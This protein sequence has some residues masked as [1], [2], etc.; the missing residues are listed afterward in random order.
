[1]KNKII[2][3]S[4]QY[5]SGGLKIGK[6]LADALGCKCYDSSAIRKAADN[7]S[8]DASFTSKDSLAEYDTLLSKLSDSKGYSAHDTLHTAECKVITDLAASD[9]PCIIIGRCADYILKE[10]NDVL[11]VFLYAPFE[12][13]VKRWLSIYDTKSK[14]PELLVKTVDVLRASYYELYTGQ[15]FGAIEN[16]NLC[17]DTSKVGHDAVVKTILDAFNH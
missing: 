6:D 7:I 8:K 3:I 17:I 9:K 5:G 4:R 12:N 2:T 1:M 16:Y 11:R 14:S 10:R 15:K 13:R